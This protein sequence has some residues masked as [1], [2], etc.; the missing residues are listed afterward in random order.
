MSEIDPPPHVITATPKTPA[1]NLTAMSIPILVATAERAV[2][3]TNKMLQILYTGWR[4]YISLIGPNRSGPNAKPR[5]NTDTTKVARVSEVLL[6]SAITSG[7]PGA[8]I[9]EAN[10]LE[11][12]QQLIRTV[13]RGEL[14]LER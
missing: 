12:F 13:E 7:T 14:T 9:D 5:T 3:T 4:P 1:K 8:N 11:E 2:K 10:G 6:N